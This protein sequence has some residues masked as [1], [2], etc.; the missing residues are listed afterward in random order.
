MVTLLKEKK[1]NDKCHEIIRRAFAF[2]V[3]NRAQQELFWPGAQNQ[4]FIQLLK[5]F[6]KISSKDII[7]NFIQSCFNCT[8]SKSGRYPD[9]CCALY[10]YNRFKLCFLKKVLQSTFSAA[11]VWSTFLSHRF[12]FQSWPLQHLFQFSQ[13]RITVLALFI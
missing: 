5:N 11:L 10:I 2:P 6:I 9:I 4:Q 12:F 7:C 1:I 13:P 8:D 3:G